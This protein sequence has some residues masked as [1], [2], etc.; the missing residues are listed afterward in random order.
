MKNLKKIREAKNLTQQNIAD[1]LNIQRPTYTRYENGEREPD[2]ETVLKLSEIL[3]VSVDYLLGKTD[4]PTTL[5]EE[6]EGEEFALWG[7]VHD[8]SEEEKKKVL[9]FIRF[10]KSQRDEKN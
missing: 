4:I 1:M 6:L 7:E 2:F 5:D 9:E 8:L 3:E 10:T